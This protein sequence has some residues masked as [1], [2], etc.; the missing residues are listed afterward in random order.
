MP[1]VCF[2]DHFDNGKTQSSAFFRYLVGGG[3]LF[4]PIESVEEN[5]LGCTI[6]TGAEISDA[7]TNLTVF[8]VGSNDDRGIIIGVFHCVAG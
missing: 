8:I 4:A 2:G 7:E 3:G 5:L 1:A 6:N